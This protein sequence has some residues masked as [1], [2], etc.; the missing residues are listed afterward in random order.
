MTA[1]DDPRVRCG[2]GVGGCR[3]LQVIDV[4]DLSVRT[5]PVVVPTEVGLP[6]GEEH[7]LVLRATERGYGEI[8]PLRNEDS[9]E[10]HDE[11]DAHVAYRAPTPPQ[12]AHRAP[13]RDTK[14]AHR[15][16]LALMVGRAVEGG[17]V[18]GGAVAVG[19]CPDLNLLMR[20]TMSLSSRRFSMMRAC[21]AGMIMGSFGPWA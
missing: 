11:R 15:V 12:E 9:C 19:T 21:S 2:V 13:A 4:L 14:R 5:D 1:T 6:V 7:G 17:A 16:G 8:P 18:S 10:E 3:R 20:V